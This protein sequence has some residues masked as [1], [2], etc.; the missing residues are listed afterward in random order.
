[1]I[2]DL[3]LVFANFHIIEK[4]EGYMWKELQ[5]NYNIADTFRLTSI[6][7]WLINLLFNLHQFVLK[8]IYKIFNALKI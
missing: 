5:L 8:I 3:L 2:A 7:E 4:D 6:R 1:M